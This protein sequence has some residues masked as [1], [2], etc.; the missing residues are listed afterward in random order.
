MAE[1]GLWPYNAAQRSGP[2]GFITEIQDRVLNYRVVPDGKLYSATVA[3]FQAS[4]AVIY[5]SMGDGSALRT[6]KYDSKW[7]KGK[8]TSS[9]L[10][11]PFP[12][13]SWRNRDPVRKGCPL[14]GPSHVLEVTVSR[15]SDVSPFPGGH[16]QP[17]PDYLG[18]SVAETAPVST[19]KYSRQS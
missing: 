16:V 15:R 4:D 18:H 11:P 3:D 17:P 9:S 10:S 13:W 7:L 14:S 5:R 19:L 8:H 2:A 1:M 12:W 6:I